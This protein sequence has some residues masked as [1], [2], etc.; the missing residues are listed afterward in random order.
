ML[1]GRFRCPIFWLNEYP[2]PHLWQYISSAWSKLPHAPSP[3]TR[4][5][6]IETIKIDADKK[7]AVA[8]DGHC[9]AVIDVTDLLEPEE[10]SFL[11][12]AP[13]VKAAQQLLVTERARFRSKED[14]KK[15]RPVFIRSSEDSVTVFVGGSRRGVSFD[16]PTG[17]FPQWE[18]VVTKPE[19]YKFGITV[20]AAILLRLTDALHN[21]P[22]RHQGVSLFV[23][24]E[25]SP[26]IVSVESDSKSFALLMAQRGEYKQPTPFWIPKV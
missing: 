11:I 18:R 7:V 3:P 2:G 16:I 19:G 17:R 9:M 20:D 24:D 25:K 10:K 8:T 13:A 26:I 23:K 14:K 4:G 22:V 12:P 6:W 21:G 1:L 15:A 5:A